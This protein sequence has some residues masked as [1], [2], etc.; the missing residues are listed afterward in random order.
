MAELGKLK[1]IRGGHRTHAN[2]LIEKA[3]K[4]PPKGQTMLEDTQILLATVIKKLE[5]LEKC[6]TD[7]LE[8]MAED[9]DIGKEIEESL[10]YADR[11]IEARTKL[12]LNIEYV[13]EKIA[14]EKAPKKQKV[15][16]GAGLSVIKKVEGHIKLPKIVLKEYDGSLLKWSNFWDQFDASVNKRDDLSDIQK[17]TYLKSFLIGDAERAI[18]G[19]SLNSDNYKIAVDTLNTR[20]GNKQSRVSAH[21]KELR[22]LKT[23]QNITNVV[24][25]RAMYDT[26]EFNIS[27]LKELNIDVSTYGSLLI[28]IIFDRIPED[29]RIKISEKFGDEEWKFR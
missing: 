15:E 13:K 1:K 23:V 12:E 18:Q 26:L 22:S 19:L 8:K 27:N 29:L 11:L 17:F 14:E 28:A 6:D 25:M 7:I 2:K 3:T 9:D 21:M 4:D 20:F 16:D 10:G 5:V 24:G